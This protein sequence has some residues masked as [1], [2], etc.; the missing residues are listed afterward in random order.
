MFGW[1]PA[2]GRQRGSPEK[3]PLQPPLSLPSEEV[4]VHT[5]V[6]SLWLSLGVVQARLGRLR[7]AQK[8][9]A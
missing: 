8:W 7:F 2:C 4:S 3:K 9:G 6:F 1:A 5:G